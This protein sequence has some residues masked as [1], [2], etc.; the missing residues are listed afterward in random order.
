M[1]EVFPKSY[2]LTL[3]LAQGAERVFADLDV[4]Y[5]N[6]VT[7]EALR[8][9]KIKLGSIDETRSHE[10]LVALLER[11]PEPSDSLLGLFSR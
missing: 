10:I 5:S 6:G 1:R 4:H 7:W 9:K 8:S 11:L 2:T 3:H